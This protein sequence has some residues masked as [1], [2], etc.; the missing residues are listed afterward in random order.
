LI[1]VLVLLVAGGGT[2]IALLARGD[3]ANDDARERSSEPTTTGGATATD[4]ASTDASSSESSSPDPSEPESSDSGSGDD[5]GP[6][7]PG[8][9][10]DTSLFRSSPRAADYQD[11][12]EFRWEDTTMKARAVVARDH[13]DCGEVAADGELVGLGCN[14]A[15]TATYVN[16]R[17]QVTITHY[18]L[19]F[20]DRAQAQE[21]KAIKKLDSLLKIEGDAVWEDWEQGGWRA[22]QVKRFVVLTAVTGPKDADEQTVADYLRWSHTDFSLA[23]KISKGL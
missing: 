14:K 23:L 6:A 21:V 10:P 13:P 3:D 4:S 16:E 17:D 2:A 1:V 9:G 19:R 22:S 12:W 5:G 15:V 7:A 11:D 20:E 18:F 8:A